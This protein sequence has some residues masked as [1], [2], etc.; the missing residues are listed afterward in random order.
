MGSPT[1]GIDTGLTVVP[2]NGRCLMGDA[3]VELGRLIG[4]SVVTA[5]SCST[6]FSPAVLE[7]RSSSKAWLLLG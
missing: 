2:G 4:G 7:D 3:P 5:A 6:S 1:D